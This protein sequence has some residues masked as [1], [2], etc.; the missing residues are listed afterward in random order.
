MPSVHDTP[1]TPEGRHPEYPH[2]VYVD[3]EDHYGSYLIEPRAPEYHSLLWSEDDLDSAA[4]PKLIDDM[5][6]YISEDY[7]LHQTEEKEHEHYVP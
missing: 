2:L 1:P 6:G 5:E 4:D 7:F 3:I